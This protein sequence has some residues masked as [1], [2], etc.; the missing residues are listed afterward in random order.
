VKATSRGA[1]GWQ[2]EARDAWALGALLSLF[3]ASR[4][5]W[6]LWNPESVHYWEEYYRWTAA[7]ELLNGP[8][9]PL[10]DYQADHYQGGSLVAVL[11]T[12][13]SFLLFGESLLSAK[14]SAL[15]FSGATLAALYLLGRSAFGRGVAVLASLAYLAGPPLVAR[16]GLMIMG[17][18]GESAL[19]SLV[20]LALFLA[21]LQGRWRT[22][23]VFGLL[24]LV[25]GV[26]LWFCFT[27]GLSVVA[28]AL[29]WV[30]C[31]RLPRPRELGFL[32][33]GTLLGLIPWLVYNASYEFAGTL[34]IVELFGVGE[35]IDSWARQSLWEKAVGLFLHDLPRGLLLPFG[36]PLPRGVA[37][38]LTVSFFAPLALAL[39][40]G[41]VRALRPFA[42]LLPGRGV[43]AP[44]V[45]PQPPPEFVFYVYAGVFLAAFL[46]SSF[47]TELERG[48]HAY[49]ILL[50]PA[51]LL[52]LPMAVSAD[53]A[54]AAG[55]RQRLAALFGCGL[56]LASSAAGTLHLAAREPRDTLVVTSELAECIDAG[57]VVRGLLLHRKYERDPSRV[58]AEAR[59]V[60]DLKHRFHVFQGVG[61]GFV[62]R[63]EGNGSAEFMPHLQSLVIGERAAVISGMRATAA[64]QLYHYQTVAAAGT[65]T[66]QQ[67]IRLGRLSQLYPMLDELWE[68]V[69]ETL[70]FVDRIV[71]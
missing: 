51:T 31:E 6:L 3:L 12:A 24:G 30:I 60:E 10:L 68:Q 1:A 47:T 23:P 19:F 45:R 63:F 53:R 32:V 39:A 46:A 22:P 35:P 26:G 50:A 48:A 64:R 17:S 28:C 61:W 49:R 9:Q 41:L 52:L 7:W 42:A 66:V 11:L 70:R 67:R 43:A 55:G 40:I 4:L 57:N 44:A 56:L 58:F 34:R 65:A 2:W 15:L 59:R 36:D 20:Q 29:T 27:S 5:V 71:Y 62:F 38:L 13:A 18:H 14:A 16:D 69:P 25:T 54:L 8:V 21:I 33:V 37:S